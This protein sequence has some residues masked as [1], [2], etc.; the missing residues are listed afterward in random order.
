MA[1]RAEG[2]TTQQGTCYTVYDFRTILESRERAGLSFAVRDRNAVHLLT[3]Q[4]VLE[5]HRLLLGIPIEPPFGIPV[6]PPLTSGRPN[7][8][9]PST[10]TRGIPG[11]PKDPDYQQ[12]NRSREESST[13]TFAE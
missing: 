1:I 8:G 11:I 6:K 13:T 9:I 5:A 2:N 10:P 3:E 7:V 4:D 12:K